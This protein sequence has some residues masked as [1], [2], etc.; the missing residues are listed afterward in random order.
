MIPIEEALGM[1]APYY[2]LVLVL[3][4]VI[5]FFKLFSIPNK[6]IFLLPWKLLFVAVLIYIVEEIL[7]VLVKMNVIQVPRILNAIFEFFII[8][9]FIYLLLVQKDYLKREGSRKKIKKSSKSSTI[10]KKRTKRKGTKKRKSI[11]QVKR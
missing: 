1:V 7:T 2:N 9:I 10:T 8:S 4:V 5:M 11:S 6:N 3:I